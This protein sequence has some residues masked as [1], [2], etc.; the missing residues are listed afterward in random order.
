M[1][2]LCLSTRIPHQEIRW[3]FLHCLIVCYQKEDNHIKIFWTTNP[4][5]PST[6]FLAK[7][8][9]STSPISINFEKVKPCCLYE[10]GWGVGVGLG[11]WLNHGYRAII[12]LHSK[13]K[14]T[15][16]INGRGKSCNIFPLNVPVHPIPSCFK[17]FIN[18]IKLKHLS[19]YI[20]NCSGSRLLR[21]VYSPP[22][23]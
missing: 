20:Q 13:N 21:Q 17:C 16:F 18:G 23:F 14:S 8:F 7:I 10:G 3:Y 22:V 6:P 9:R 1:T 15:L 4:F 2:F 19:T 12:V 5:C 11:G